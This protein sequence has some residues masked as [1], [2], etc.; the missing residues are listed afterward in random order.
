MYPEGIRY[1]DQGRGILI[2]SLDVIL[3]W[4]ESD[5]DRGDCSNDEGELYKKGIRLLPKGKTRK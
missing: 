4:S 2:T 3:L 5:L 1:I